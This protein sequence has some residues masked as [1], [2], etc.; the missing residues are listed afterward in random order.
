MIAPDRPSTEQERLADLQALQLLDTPPEER[1]DRLVRLAMDVF[2]VPIAYL[3]LI[4]ADR[5]WL[6][7]KCGIARDQTGRDESFCG[8]TIL[9]QGPLIVNDASADPRFC[10]NPLVVKSPGI[11]FY[12]G[13]PLA[14]PAGY[15]VGTL[16]IADTRSRSL[17]DRE[18]S[19]FC[20]L[21]TLAQ[22][23]VSLVDLVTTQRELLRAQETLAATQRRLSR[24]LSDAAA[25]VTSMLPDQLTNGPVR[26]AHRFIACSELGGDMIGVGPPSGC[27]DCLAFYLLDVSGHGVGSSLLSIAVANAIRLQ[28]LPG[29]QFDNPAS[30][31]TALNKAFPAEDHHDKFFTIWYGSYHVPSRQLTFASGG[32]HPAILLPADGSTPKQLG[33][34][35]PLVGMFD[36]VSYENTRLEIAPNS[37]LYLFSDGAFELSTASGH[38]LGFDALTSL[39][40]TARGDDRLGEVVSQLEAM[41]SGSPE[42]DLTLLEL[43]FPGRADV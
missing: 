29:V 9:G 28:S 6:K 42:D 38:P 17:T 1:F 43:H 18:L 13:H 37:R 31:L 20:R 35:G 2:D 16:C 33:N 12:A 19:A 41:R 36:E 40:A 23:E 21:A 15:N 3:A 5:Q 22:H 4:D 8:H 7:A 10:D 30:V 39:L 26:T 34:P 27:S 11:R 25:F 24:E 32:H 14:G